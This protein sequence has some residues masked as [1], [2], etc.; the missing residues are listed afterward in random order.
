MKRINKTLLLISVSMVCLQAMGQ[1]FTASFTTAGSGDFSGRV[2]LYLSKESKS[3]KDDMPGVFSFPCFS[4]DVKDVKPGQKVVFDDAAVSYPAALS[5]IERGIYYAQVV[6]DRNEGGRAIGGSPGNMYNKAIVASITKDRTKSFDIVCSE[7]IKEASF[8]ETQFVKELK[9]PSALLTA[10][11]K[12]ATSV[13]AAVILPK[14]YFSQPNRKFP[15]L[16]WVS[17]YG[18]DYHNYSGRNITSDP[19]DTTQCIRV[20]LDGNCPGGHSVYANSDNN[21]PWGDALTKELIPLVEKTYRTNAARLL[22]GH[23]SGG[24]TVLWLQTHYPKVFN[25]CWSSSPD[26]VDFR[27]FQQ[28]DLYREKNLYYAKDST[29]HM[30]AT[31]AGRYP[32]ISQ[33][34]MCSME[35]V[36]YRGEQMHSFNFVF[37]TR[38]PDGTPRG[39]WNDVTGEID[40][41]I[42][43]HWKNYDICLY[44]KNNWQQV[45]PDL[46]GKIRVSVG[47]QDNFLLNYAVHLLDGEMK[48]VDAGFVFGYY[49]GDH[50]TV[51]TPE[52]K[53][54]GHR[55]L[56]QKYNELGIKN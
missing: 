4:I 54:A 11:Y 47:E 28:V 31:V 33:K 18:G 39:M 21:G 15:V 51:S 19:I 36:I 5:D 48:K 8:T 32:W 44:L 42:V 37:S 45:K 17:G 25:A 1:K 46:Q 9:S 41:V 14:E 34:I 30:A 2:L 53:S 16:Y 3:P 49:P 38:N 40:P 7:V 22:T 20:F 27:S 29:M 56:E 52:Y 24:W 12:R 43:E 26:P 6:W 10:F 23:S 13:N 55:F 50:F 35:H